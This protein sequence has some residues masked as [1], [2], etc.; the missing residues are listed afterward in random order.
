MNNNWFEIIEILKPVINGDRSL[1]EVKLAIEGCLRTLGWRS[2]TGKMK[3]NY[4]TSSGKNID[5]VLGSNSVD[6][7]FHPILPIFAFI[8]ES[9]DYIQQII[10]AVTSQLGV[11]VAIVIDKRINL[12][13]KPTFNSESI[14][15]CNIPFDIKDANGISLS[16]LLS[17]QGFSK[18]HLYEYFEKHYKRV[19]PAIKLNKLLQTITNDSSKAEEVLKLYLKIKGFEGEVVD[20]ALKD[21][22]INIYY[23]KDR[24]S[25]SQG[26][27]AVPQPCELN[28]TGHDNTRFSLNGGP[29]LSKRS[30]VQKVVSQYVHDNPFV[31]LEDLEKRF[32][33]ELASK[34]RGVVRTLA[35]VQQW[36]SENGADILTRYCT[37]QNEIIKLHDGTEV[38]VNSQ[39][40][41]KNFPKFL[42]LAKSL[43]QVSS[44]APYDNS[45]RVEK[46]SVKHDN[47][48]RSFKFSMIDV[49]IGEY[50]TFDAKNIK[51]KVVSD[52]SV[53][54]QG[55]VY[56]LT[57][58]VRTFLPEQLRTPSDSY[59]GPDF[60]SYKGEKLTKLR[61]KKECETQSENEIKS[62][63]IQ[64]SQNSLN[65]FRKNE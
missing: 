35:Q 24:N 57:T 41:S 25:E 8:N 9:A 58:F 3:I 19:L 21:I 1:G 6:G 18:D 2:S 60:F 64:I 53:E 59:R 55:N 56:K 40:G 44:S 49:N 17:E 33:S 20:D 45:G 28:T 14:C 54:Y 65:I 47:K 46:N 34:V 43:Y 30:F 29:Y 50:V 61:N 26:N 52:D 27:Y 23:K 39:W 22:E 11:N 42:A 10:D 15:V 4:R 62:N 13:L 48:A 5:V 63:G 7:N 16:N 36:A 51:V 31:S 32:P 37:K 12:Y 38:V